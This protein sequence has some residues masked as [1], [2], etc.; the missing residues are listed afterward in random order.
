MTMGD[1]GYLTVMHYVIGIANHPPDVHTLPN[2]YLGSMLPGPVLIMTLR[3]QKVTSLKTN[4][5]V[6]PDHI[7]TGADGSGAF[8]TSIFVASPPR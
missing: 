5:L 8:F 6:I 3:L 1:F 2:K 7:T 4:R